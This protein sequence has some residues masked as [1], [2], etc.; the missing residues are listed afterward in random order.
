MSDMFAARRPDVVV[1]GKADIVVDCP[2]LDAMHP[3][4]ITVASQPLLLMP[5]PFVASEVLL[6]LLLRLGF[7]ALVSS[8]AEGVLRV[9]GVRLLFGSGYEPPR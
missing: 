4:V 3:V 2:H 5:F 9:V 1:V 6:P 8:G 7:R